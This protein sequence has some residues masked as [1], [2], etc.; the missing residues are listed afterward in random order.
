MTKLYPEYSQ[1][2]IFYVAFH[3]LE[4]LGKIRDLKSDKIGHLLSISGTITRTTEVRPELIQGVFTCI[5]CNTEIRGVDQQFRYTQPK[6]CKNP[7]CQNRMKWNLNGNDSVF[8][9]WQKLRVQEN[10]SEIP[11]GG[12]PRSIDVI[13]RNEM[14]DQVNPG[15]SSVF[16][17]ILIVVPEVS[18]LLKPGD[19]ARIQVKNQPTR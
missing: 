10:A 4:T 3:N 2:K 1:K 14:V 17:G 8:C 12:M 19:R 11:A 16:T 18:S 7:S 15:D 13:L 9:D 6:V 5:A